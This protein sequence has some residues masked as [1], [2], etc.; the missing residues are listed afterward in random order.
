MQ[1]LARALSSS[2]L[3]LKITSSAWS[4]PASKILRKA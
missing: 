2:P 1:E 3:T 4:D